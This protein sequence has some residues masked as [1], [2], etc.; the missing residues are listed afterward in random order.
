MAEGR[1]VI[2]PRTPG[3]EHLLE[4][5]QGP[6]PPDLDVE[7]ESVLTLLA[8]A[9]ALKPAPG[10]PI[11]AGRV[12]EVHGTLGIDPEPLLAR[13]R[14]TPTTDPTLDSEVA[15]L[16]CR[17]ELDRDRLDDFH[18]TGKPHLIVRVVDEVTTLGPFVRPGAT[19][20]LRCLDQHR[21]DAD[22]EHLDVVRRY[23]LACARP[24][25]DGAPEPL[26]PMLATLAT[27]WAVRDLLTYLD[28]GRP[29][30]WSSTI[31]LPAC[32]TGLTAR[33]WLRHPECPCSWSM[34]GRPGAA[35]PSGTLGR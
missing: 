21:A 19:A 3:T 13:V 34:P 35:S 14:L 10:P 25:A 26:D 32:L 4:A 8:D 31:D 24:R 1:R 30:T 29:A 17:G 23:A 12:V 28:G 15:L 7:G 16:L 2:L 6:E 9:G 22:P 11:G 27:C 33:T 18:R 5:M 20:C